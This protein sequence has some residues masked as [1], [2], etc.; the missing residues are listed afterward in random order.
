[1]VYILHKKHSTNYL[2]WRHSFRRH[3]HVPVVTLDRSHLNLVVAVRFTLTDGESDAI[4]IINGLYARWSKKFY[5]ALHQSILHGLSKASMHWYADP[6][7]YPKR[8]PD[9]NA[10]PASIVLQIRHDLLSR[11]QRTSHVVMYV[12]HVPIAKRHLHS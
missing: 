5:V 9:N 11:R 1:M 12:F 2:Y 7:I 8:C 6:G 4:C 3:V 10:N